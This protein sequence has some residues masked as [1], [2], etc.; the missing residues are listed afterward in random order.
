MLDQIRKRHFV[1]LAL[2]GLLAALGIIYFANDASK[3]ANVIRHYEHEKDFDALVPVI[4]EN[5]FWLSERPDF[6]PEKFL[7]WRAPNFDPA[8]KGEATIDVIEVDK[9]TAGF[10]AYYKKSPTHGFIWLFAVD[11]KFRRRGLGDKLMA[12]ALKQLKS[13]GAQYVTLTTRLHKTPAL[14]LYQKAGFVEQ[15][16]EEDRGLI[17]LIKRFP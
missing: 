3:E 9:E 8:R 17:T 2:L 11:Q 1:L 15:D 12:H 13:Q 14:Q 5:M 4:R 7:M 16:R 10:I 6:S